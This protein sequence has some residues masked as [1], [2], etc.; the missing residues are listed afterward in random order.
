MKI[1]MP[2]VGSCMAK[3]CAYNLEEKCHARAITVG[4]GQTC[5]CDTF[6]GGVGHVKGKSRVAGVGACKIGGC[7][8]NEDF[9]CM[10][11]SIS[12][13]LD[14]DNALCTTYAT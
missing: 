9:E 10:A 8:Y 13:K 14:G 6:L 7:Q 4:D 3:E 12:V 1:V 5:H 11:D 2:E